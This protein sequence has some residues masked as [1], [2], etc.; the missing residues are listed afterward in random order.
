MKPASFDY[1]RP[2]SLEEAFTVLN[3][4]GESGKVLAG[5]QS[6]MPI[7]NMRLSTPESLIDINHLHE[8]DYI[9]YEDSWLKIGSL[10]RQNTILN[11]A[12]A[13]KKA[14]LLSEAIPFIG[15]MQTRNRGTI[16]GSIVHADP[17]AELAVS[18]L[19]MDGIAVISSNG[20]VREVPL[21][22]FF[23]T[24]LTTDIAFNELLTEIKIKVDDLPKGYSFQEVNRRHG[25]FALVDASCVMEVDDHSRIT[26]IRLVLGGVDAVPVLVEDAATILLGEKLTESGLKEVCRVT[27]ENIDPDTDLHASREYRIHLA[28]AYTKR[29][30]QVAYGR[31]CGRQGE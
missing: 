10:T 13:A 5:G 21:K 20:E 8:L 28:Q 6:L 27:T 17:T 26:D 12:L 23:I 1:Y 31:A 14:P 24:Y 19:C 9:R 30:I 18:C 3:Q 11:S 7:L 4:Y 2:D 15:H 29:A 25:D 16:G 22:D